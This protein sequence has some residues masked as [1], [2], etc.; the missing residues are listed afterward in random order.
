MSE[1]STITNVWLCTDFSESSIAPVLEWF[2]LQGS[3][4]WLA[5][6]QRVRY[7]GRLYRVAVLRTKDDTP[8][9]TTKGQLP[10]SLDEVE[11]TIRS[12]AALEL[13]FVLQYGAPCYDGCPRTAT[14]VIC[15]QFLAN[16][17]AQQQYYNNNSNCVYTPA[18]TTPTAAAAAAVPQ[19]GFLHCMNKATLCGRSVATSL[20]STALHF[21]AMQQGLWSTE[22][23]AS[24]LTLSLFIQEVALAKS[25]RP[26]VIFVTRAECLSSASSADAAVKAVTA[27]IATHATVGVLLVLVAQDVQAIDP[28]LRRQVTMSATVH[29]PNLAQRVELFRHWMGAPWQEKEILLQLA[30][31]SMTLLE[32]EQQIPVVLA[33]ASA[34]IA[35][36]SSSLSPSINQHVKEEEEQSRF[37][38]SS[39]TSASAPAHID[40]I[41]GAMKDL[42]RITTAGF[43]TEAPPDATSF[44]QIGGLHKVKA[45]LQEIMDYLADP[46]SFCKYGRPP[47][48]VL[49]YGPPGCGK[50]QI[51]R[52]LA[53]ES[54]ATMRVV[55][56]AELLSSYFGE[57]EQQVRAVFAEARR[58]AP[59][60]IFFDEFD[61]LSKRRGSSSDST[62]A[63]RVITQ[64]LTELDG[65]QQREGVIVLAATNRLD[66]I[67]EAFL[68]VGRFD[69]QVF[70]GPAELASDRAIV[71]LCSLPKGLP[72][73]EAAVNDFL[74]SE[75]FASNTRGWSG[76]QLK[77]LANEACR[78]VRRR[79]VESQKEEKLMVAD[80][81][82]Y[83]Q[84]K[85]ETDA[86]LRSEYHIVDV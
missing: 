4:T 31:A 26:A 43:A 83:L 73:D 70:V 76:A 86:D 10:L 19:H 44:K 9:A 3:K 27:A 11:V 78:S 58:H 8:P 37:S 12:G 64:L 35:S 65:Y 34:A 80:L 32:S 7:Q 48:G 33:K 77:G 69:K 23:D 50:T 67:D 68:R 20:D 82:R 17:D 54:T 38:S 55:N 21:A 39:S 52:A 51:A 42:H 75:E 40:A 53:T 5:L 57:S 29:A 6:N 46:Q 56:A 84:T 13:C 1:L 25:F 22:L 18:M 62:V 74:G 15:R 59:C 24:T 16:H 81:Q 36:H 61:A 79:W 71:V 49:L 66:V 28:L 41:M 14:K 30:E 60:I 72:Y 85:N 47:G 2:D 63:D 45:E